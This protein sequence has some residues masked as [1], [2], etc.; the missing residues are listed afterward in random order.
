MRNQTLLD[1]VLGGNRRVEFS[2]LLVLG[3]YL[4]ERCSS[5]TQSKL[6]VNLQSSNEVIT[7]P[8]ECN[9]TLNVSAGTTNLSAGLALQRHM[10]SA[11]NTSG[12]APQRKE[13]CTLQCTLS[14]EEEKSSYL[15]AVL[16]TTSIRLV[17]NIV[18]LTP[19]VPPSKKDYEIMFQPLFDEYF[20]PPPR[21]VSLDPIAVAAQELLIHLGDLKYDVKGAQVN[22][23]RDL[24]DIDYQMANAM[25]SVREIN[26]FEKKKKGLGGRKDEFNNRDVLG[27]QLDSKARY[28]T[29]ICDDCGRD[30]DVLVMLLVDV[31]DAA[32]EFALWDLEKKLLDQMRCLILC[33]LA[34]F[35]TTPED[36]EGKPLYDSDKSSDSKTTG[37]ATCVSS[38]KS[39]SSK[40]N[41]HLASASSLVDF[42]TVSKTAD[43]KPSSTIDN[44]SF[45]F[46]E[47]VKTSRN[48]CNKRGINNRSYCKN[49][50]FGSKTCFVCGSKF[51]LIKDCDFYKQHLGL[52]NKPM[53]HN[54]ANIPSFVPEA[55][56]V[57]AGSRNPPASVS[58]GSVVPAG[59]RNIPASVPAGKPLSVGWRNHAARPMT[60]PTSHYFQHFRRPGCY[61]Q[62]YMDEGRWGTAVK[63]L[64]GAATSIWDDCWTLMMMLISEI[65]VMFLLL[66]LIAFLWVYLLRNI[67]ASFLTKPDPLMIHRHLFLL[68]DVVP[69]GSRNYTALFL[70][71]G[72]YNQLYTDEGRWGTAVKTLAGPVSNGLGFFFVI[73][74]VVAVLF[75]FVAQALNDSD[76]VEA[77]QEEMQQFINQRYGSL[78]LW[79]D[80]ENC[81][82]WMGMTYDE[83]FAPVARMKLLDFLLR[84]PHIMGFYGL[85]N[86]CERSP[87]F[88]GIDEG[89]TPLTSNLNAVKKIFKYLKG[90]PKLGLLVPEISFCV[91]KHYSDSD[92]MLVHRVIES[93]LVDVSSWLL[94]IMVSIHSGWLSVSSGG[95]RV[96][97]GSFT[98]SYWL[99]TSY[100]YALTHDPIIFDSLVKQFWSTASLRA[101]ELGSP[102]ILDMIGR[103][104]VPTGK[105]NVIVSAGRSKVIP[106]GR[107][108]LVL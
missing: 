1:L 67:H 48:I 84:L 27:K 77:M 42:K 76:W 102:A 81:N 53:W 33:P 17:Q 37:F 91:R 50:S 79:P 96:P 34:I 5:I 24:E 57:P 41:D 58:T 9:Q 65:L 16:S 86:G 59:S 61:N 23:S 85:S 93:Q 10:A 106:A 25:L 6:T 104:V 28:C 20:N 39:S 32:A 72:C 80:G 43:Q 69:A 107:T 92:Y 4:L 19:Y 95:S 75:N 108:I 21:A 70:L 11:D 14:L 74:N 15:R 62:L 36:V 60:R 63:N 82:K 47:N 44:P 51:H 87:S 89:V 98:G 52:Y 12:P 26:R 40:T 73:S 105:D 103:Y 49:N 71:P 99:T 68:V 66:L 88:M 35:D 56:Y 2:R 83:V 97:T 45:Y 38:A 31:S 101:P 100:W 22:D 55:A 13:R 90:Q 7:N 30:D 78:S 18:S 8:Y 46:K 94:T 3:G 54:A 29:S 64:A